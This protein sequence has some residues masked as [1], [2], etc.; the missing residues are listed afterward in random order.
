MIGHFGVRRTTKTV[1]WQFF[2]KNMKSHMRRHIS[3]SEMCMETKPDLHEIQ[4]NSL[5]VSASNPTGIISIDIVGKSPRC[6][7]YTF[8]LFTVG[9]AAKFVMYALRNANSADVLN[10][11]NDFCKHYGFPC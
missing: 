11:I 1:A 8:I 9:V 2:W 6:R 7:G 5:H 3:D 10:R 4:I